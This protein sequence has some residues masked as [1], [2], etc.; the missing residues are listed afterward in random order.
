MHLFGKS[1]WPKLTK[2]DEDMYAL[3]NK[4]PQSTKK[5]LY[6]ADLS[7]VGA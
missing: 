7:R 2:W 4:K 6:K 5:V 3:G 1:V